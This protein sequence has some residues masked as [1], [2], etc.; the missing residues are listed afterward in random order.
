MLLLGVVQAQAAGDE[1]LSSFDLL[2]TQVLPSNQSSV[3]FVNLGTKYAAEYKHLQIRS[4]ARA[5]F[6]SGTVRGGLGIRFNGDSGANYA[7]HVLYGTGSAVQSF[8]DGTTTSM[9]AFDLTFSSSA[10]PEYTPNVIDILDPFVTTKNT[11][12]RALG[13]HANVGGTSRLGFSSGA[14]F[15]TAALTSITLFAEGHSLYSGSRFSL[16]GIKA[17]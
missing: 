10:G 17:D 1:F 8:K 2:E 15:N 7:T 13:G 16:Y 14:Y 4:L 3:E 5:T 9:I 11:T 6:P 12:I